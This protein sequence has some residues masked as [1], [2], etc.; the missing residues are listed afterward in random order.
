MA[1]DSTLPRTQQ[2]GAYG[3][4]RWVLVASLIGLVF[5]ALGV[6]VL[7]DPHGGQSLLAAIYDMI[8]NSAGATAL[9]NGQGDQFLA[10]L[11]LAVI[12]LLVGVGGIWLLFTGAST[13]VERF[14]AALRDR[15]LPWVFIGPAILLLAIYL[16]YPAV[17]TVLRSFQDGDGAFT[18]ANWTSLGKGEFL[19]IL[20]NNVIWL[21]V[22]T[23]GSVGL[24]LIVAALFD[25]IR[26]ESLAKVF[27]F[28]PLA[29]SLVGA[30]VIW[31]FV[32]AQQPPSQPQF[33]LLNAIWTA[34]GNKPIAWATTFPINLPA[35]MVIMIWLQTGFAMVVLSAAIK[36][37]SVEVLE[38]ARLDGASERQ[39]FFGVIIPL[40]RGSIITVATTIAI[41]TLKIFDIVW[42]LSGGIN[43]DSVVAVRMFQ[44]MFQFFNDGRAAALATVL[45]IAVL[46]VMF[47]N[48]RNFRRQAAM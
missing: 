22:T 35:E 47:V 39:I 27:V 12:A 21:V 4:P 10:K 9:R 18:L 8:G 44:E 1:V 40:I 29:I 17:A 16:V 36:G 15:V 19:E 6:K 38:A 45:F 3:T 37:V 32:Y 7:I 14:P 24:G 33:G 43:H 20:R 25:R 41:A 42:S 30:T 13:I 48:L 5:A 23:A 46:P 28:T 2:S 34:F 11:L 31:K 26:R